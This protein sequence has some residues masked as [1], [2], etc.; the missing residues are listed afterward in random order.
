MIPEIRPAVAADAEACGRIIYEAFRG[1]ADEHGFP[2][3]FPSVE[4]ATQ[5]ATAFIADPA[6]YGVVAETAGRVV[7]SNFL[8]EGDAIRGVGPITVDPAVQGG[9]V[10]RRLMQVVLDRAREA[11]GVRLVQ[12][13]FN[14]RSIALY[15]SIGFDVKE[16]LLLIRGTPRSKPSSAFTVR[17]MTSEDISACAELCTAAHGI[18]RSNELRGAIQHFT[19]FV[20]EHGNR[21][22]GYLSA[23]TFWLMNH[24]VA[25]TEQDMRAL[26]AGAASMS[27]E[28][29]SF[30]LPMRQA[31]FF[32]WCLGEGMRVVKP[33][34]FMTMGTYQEPR[35]CY[36]PS[37]LY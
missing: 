22:T 34:T 33:M 9:G 14:M 17:P 20:V 13:A 30:L 29:V 26:V 8:A 2:R 28:P 15:A 4:A 1:I 6:I 10:G 32:R 3:D 16:P 36:F 27:S 21:V 23:A 19:P 24:G 37:V 5:L 35:G 25:G 18:E 7:G 11:V 12:D 31:S